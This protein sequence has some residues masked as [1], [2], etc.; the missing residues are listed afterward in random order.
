MLCN[1]ICALH[2]SLEYPSIARHYF[3]VIVLVHTV[4]R[5][6]VQLKC[7]LIAKKRRASNRSPDF[8]EAVPLVEPPG[9][10]IGDLHVKIYVADRKL[11]RARDYK[12]QAFGT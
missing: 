3:F 9:V 6:P 2:L 1:N 10:G 5:V 4:R 12:F 7:P 11:L 8:L